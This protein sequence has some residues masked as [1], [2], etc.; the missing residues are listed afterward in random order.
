MSSEACGQ[1]DLGGKK[2][3]FGRN[4]FLL[5][6]C[7]ERWW[8]RLE[9]FANFFGTSRF[10]RSRRGVPEFFGYWVFL[11]PSLMMYCANM[12]IWLAEQNT[13]IVAPFAVIQSS[14]PDAFRTQSHRVAAVRVN[15]CCCYHTG[16][17]F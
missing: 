8:G 6:V 1:F 3:H 17:F 14:L 2:R 4:K 15:M 9:I 11:N 7:Y 10:W 12:L 5:F 16:C 13:H